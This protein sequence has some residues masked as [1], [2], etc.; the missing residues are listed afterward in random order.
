MFQKWLRAIGKLEYVQGKARPKVACILCAIRDDD[1]RVKSLKVYQDKLIFIVLNLYPYNPAH[2]MVIPARHVTKFLDLTRE[3]IH[4]CFRAVQGLQLLLNDLY[5]PQ[6]YNLGMNQGK[7]AGASIDHL[8][9]HFVPRYKSEL[10]YIDII[11]KARVV[12]EG[13]ENVK[14]K[15]ESKIHDYLTPEF[16]TNF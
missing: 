15:V 4:H 14:K 16:F 1:D 12:P 3:E 2:M 10:G 13:L 7:C 9:F 5:S 11:G 8:H 6:G